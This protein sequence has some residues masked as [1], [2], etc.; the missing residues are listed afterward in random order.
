MAARAAR[1]KPPGSRLAATGFRTTAKD[2]L[3]NRRL[4]FPLHDALYAYCSSKVNE[5]GRLEHT[6]R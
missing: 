2:D 5:S 4:E 1:R 3:E 6:G